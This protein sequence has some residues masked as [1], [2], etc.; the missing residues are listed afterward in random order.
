MKTTAERIQDLDDLLMMKNVQASTIDILMTSSW[1]KSIHNLSSAAV[2]ADI[3]L[4]SDG[5]SQ[6]VTDLVL[7]LKPRY[8]FAASPKDLKPESSSPGIYFERQPYRNHVMLQE[9]NKPVTRFISLASV[10]G[11]DGPKKGPKW[12][13]AF[14]IKP[15]S[16]LLSHDKESNKFATDGTKNVG[17]KE[18]CNQPEDTTQPPFALSIRRDKKSDDRNVQFF[19]SNENPEES[20]RGRRGRGR[21]GHD[22]GQGEGD[23]RRRFEENESGDAHQDK[24]RRNSPAFDTSQCWFCFSSPSVDKSLVVSI[25]DHAYLATAKGGLV[26]DHLLILPIEH[27]RSS[28]ESPN[29]MLIDEINKFK[30]ALSNYFRSKDKIVAFFERNFKSNHMQ[31][32]VVPMPKECLQDN[33]GKLN[34]EMLSLTIKQLISENDLDCEQLTDEEQLSDVINPGVPFFYFEITEIKIKLLIRIEIKNR[35][36]GDNEEKR[37]LFPLQLGRVILAQVMGLD[38]ESIVDWK[39]VASKLDSEQESKRTAEFRTNFE[40]FDFTIDPN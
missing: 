22:R 20:G 11:P 40:P 39:S 29:Q 3:I 9:A 10:P 34:Q 7:N 26:P 8:H 18:L 27:I 24:R 4:A 35:K 30:T 14:N 5:G 12:L 31:I 37:Q 38:D 32:Q 21:G 17:K 16:D 28:L 36:E 23:R 2:P 19:Y 13:Y 15:A 1:P 33:Q 25:G 6:L